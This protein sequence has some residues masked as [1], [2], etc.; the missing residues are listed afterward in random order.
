MSGQ[1]KTNS[2]LIPQIQSQCPVIFLTMT[3]NCS[4][5][6]VILFDYFQAMLWTELSWYSTTIRPSF[7]PTFPYQDQRA[8]N[9]FQ[10]FFLLLLLFPVWL[11]LALQSKSNSFLKENKEKPWNVYVS[12]CL[13]IL[14]WWRLMIS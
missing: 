14:E 5:A 9:V 1:I 12:Y 7:L 6:K 4:Q 8:L 3:F 13:S 11:C 10:S 2:E